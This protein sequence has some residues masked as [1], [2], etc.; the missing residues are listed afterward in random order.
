MTVAPAPA[1]DWQQV[2]DDFP[3]N[4][5]L[6]WLNNCGWSAMPGPVR[7]ALEQHLRALCEGGFIG[8]PSEEAVHGAIRARL[9]RLIG[10]DEHEVTLVHNTGEGLM[11]VSHGLRLHAGDRIVLLEH[12]YPSNIYPWQHWREAG[13]TLAFAPLGDS[14]AAFLAS[15]RPLLEPPTRVV[16]LSAVHWCTGMPLPLAEVGA[17]C[18][19]R[20]ITLVVDG[21]Q[22]VG[23]VP[24]DVRA[25]G[26][27]AMAFAA[28]KWLLG[29]PGLGALYVRRDLLAELRFPFKGTGSVVDDHNYLPYRDTLKPGADRYVLSTPNYNDWIHLDAS[30]RYLDQLGFAA[31]QA[32]IQALAQHLVRGLHDIG[33]QVTSDAFPDQRTGIVAATPPAGHDAGA[34]VAALAQRNI[35]AAARLGRVRLAPHVFLLEAQLDRVVAELRALTA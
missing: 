5:K 16:S 13:V 31:V 12:E 30:L 33:W 6:I 15:L 3:I 2:H 9:A 29:P 11:F 26:I 25:A 18:A 17:L 4:R 27:A 23:L 35:V 21:A 19:A 34:L 22:G 14:P 10:A 8:V 1:P 24:I 32:R 7:V 28:W 20:G